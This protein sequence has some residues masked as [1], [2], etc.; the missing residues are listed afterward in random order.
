[1]CLLFPLNVYSLTLENS[2]TIA[3][4]VFGIIFAMNMCVSS[5]VHVILSNIP[6]ITIICIYV[7]GP[8]SQMYIMIYAQVRT[9]LY[10]NFFMNNCLFCLPDSDESCDENGMAGS[11]Q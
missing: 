2:E 3:I 7:C 8:G 10:E 4:D 5:L 1:M 11:P 6:Y 9:D